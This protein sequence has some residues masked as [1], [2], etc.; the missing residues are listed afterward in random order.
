MTTRH[1]PPLLSIGIVLHAIHAVPMLLLAG[2]GALVAM[3]LQG[4]E[5]LGVSRLELPG[6]A[7]VLGSVVAAA[8]GVYYAAILWVCS[9]AWDGS[10]GGVIALLVLSVLGIVNTGAL[11]GLVGLITIVGAVQALAGESEARSL[12]F[13][14]EA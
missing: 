7:F 10:R 9:L 3:G 5:A 11:S 4:T 1:R 6:A 8:V 12:E 2:L 14:G 13:G